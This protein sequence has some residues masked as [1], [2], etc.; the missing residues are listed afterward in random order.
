MKQ[1]P[2]I[3]DANI[4]IDKNKIEITQDNRSAGGNKQDDLIGQFPVQAIMVGNLVS[5]EIG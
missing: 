3:K 1:K 5:N 2:V 4:Y